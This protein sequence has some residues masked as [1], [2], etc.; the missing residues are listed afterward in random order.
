MQSETPNL[1]R[2]AN[3]LLQERHLPYN[4]MGRDCFDG[5]R[6]FGQSLSLSEDMY[7]VAFVFMMR[8][9]ALQG[10]VQP[11]SVGDNDSQNDD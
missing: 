5:P 8:P 11:E 4:Q 1:N 9:E 7:S 2:R 10:A 6:N 3:L